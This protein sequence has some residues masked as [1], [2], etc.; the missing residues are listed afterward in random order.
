MEPVVGVTLSLLAHL[1]LTV[2]S[3]ST[4]LGDSL[5]EIIIGSQIIEPVPTYIS[6]V[7]IHRA[8]EDNLW[9]V[10]ESRQVYNKRGPIWRGLDLMDYA[11]YHNG[12]IAPGMYL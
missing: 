12:H 2:G 4:Q 5:T 3:T 10:H 7:P 8:L 1:N 9:A 6:A 11:R